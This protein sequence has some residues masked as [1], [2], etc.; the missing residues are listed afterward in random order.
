M[1][2]QDHTG[3][4]SRRRLLRWL[5]GACCATLGGWS[6]YEAGRLTLERVTVALEGLD[7]AFAGYR[8][9][10]LSDTHCGPWT[11]PAFI[12][13]AVALANGVR[14]D[15]IVLCG[16]F[17]QR[18]RAYIEPGIEP[19]ADC[20]APDGVFA[21][22]GNHDHWE[23]AALTVRTLRR[24]GVQP[25]TNA[26]VVVN[27]R[28]ARLALGG[29]DDLW[30]GRQDP[31]SAF[32][33]VPADVPRI[34]LSHNPDYAERLPS[35]VRIDLMLSGHTHGGQVLLPWVGAPL[36]PVTTGQKYR[37]GLVRGPRCQVYVS[38]G[39]GTITPPVRFRCPPEVTVVELA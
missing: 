18:S 24:V 37:A 13:H 7:R 25:L 10:L 36:L 28:G 19:F 17:N 26:G 30:E 15:L 39:V 16:D 3:T 9:A 14:P 31:A 34:L 2:E 29:V 11:G 23:D 35:G 32:R 22:L 4:V 20:S 27:R 8:V 33:G 12:A 5:G 1:S 38:R 21:V 6:L